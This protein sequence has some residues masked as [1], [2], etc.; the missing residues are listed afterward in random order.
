MLWNSPRTSALAR[1]WGLIFVHDRVKAA[2]EKPEPVRENPTLKPAEAEVI[3]EEHSTS[4]FLTDRELQTVL[5]NDTFLDSYVESSKTKGFVNTDVAIPA[6]W[7]CLSMAFGT[8]AYVPMSKTLEMN[9]W[10]SIAALGNG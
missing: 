2:R 3:G 5:E 9:L 1:D 8:R 7:T 10:F 4:E 6:A